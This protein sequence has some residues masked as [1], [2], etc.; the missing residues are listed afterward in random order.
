[1][2]SLAF[3]KLGTDWHFRIPAIRMAETHAQHGSGATS[4]YE[5]AWRSPTFDGCL[6]CTGDAIRLWQPRQRGIRGARGTSSPHE[7]ADAMHAAWVAFARSGNPGWPQFDV[8]RRATMRFDT[9]SQ[10]VEEPHLAERLL[11][12]GRR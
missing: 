7:V 9:I 2:F 1:M 4:M 10:L 12:E 8:K 3:Q 6:S 5:F 11:W